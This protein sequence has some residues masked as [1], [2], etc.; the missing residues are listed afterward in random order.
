[1]ETAGAAF[2]EALAL[3]PGNA[4]TAYNLGLN[5]ECRNQLDLAVAKYREAVELNPRYITAQLAL[6]R[7]Y[8]VRDEMQKAVAV[9]QSGIR[10]DPRN[11]EAHLS[12]GNILVAAGKLDEARVCF[13]NVLRIKPDDVGAN[14]GLGEVYLELGEVDQATDSYRR[15]RDLGS[16]SAGH[17][18]AALTHE[19]TQMAPRQY[20]EELFDSYS[21]DF[22]EHLIG[23][24]SYQ[25]PELLFES[26]VR[27]I[28]KNRRFHRSV[29]LGCGT[30]L[31]G[32]AFLSIVDRLDGIDLSSDMLEQAREKGIYSDLHAEDIVE[33]LNAG[34]DKYDLF[35]SADVLIYIGNLLP[36]FRAI[37]NRAT[38]GAYFVFSTE[39]EDH[40]D[41]A[42][43]T[44]G[45]YAHSEAY[46][47]SLAQTHEFTV[48]RCSSVPLRK[49]GDDWIDG[50]LFILRYLP[51]DG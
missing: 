13:E 5:L 15:A 30:G 2:L 7:I 32:Q 11:R 46:I 40:G 14:E 20:V 6:A 24:L 25:I 18:L 9:Y 51:G 36:L 22:E 42:L 44:T 27:Y 39:S 45:R 8:E 43:R 19:E 29:D 47:R 16:I 23:T 26:F 33:C 49:E 21:K 34:E 12:L 41:Y 3:E 10:L 37:K 1:M 50:Q 48:L 4:E 35:M 31:L 28:G 38:Q 17:L